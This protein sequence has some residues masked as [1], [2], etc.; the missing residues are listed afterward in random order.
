VPASD[1]GNGARSKSGLV[2]RPPVDQVDR[3]ATQPM[4]DRSELTAE[5]RRLLGDLFAI[6]EE[7]THQ[8]A[9]TIARPG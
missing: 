7:H 4:I 1:D 3:A 6:V 9:V 2:S 8:A 5:E